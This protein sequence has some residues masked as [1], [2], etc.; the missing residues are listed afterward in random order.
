M[1][2]SPA[3]PRHHLDA[4]DKTDEYI[5]CQQVTGLMGE[6]ERS[7]GAWLGKVGGASVM[8]GRAGPTL[9]EWLWE[10]ARE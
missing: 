8:Y 4:E 2:R 3:C 9:D 1:P 7:E 10:E 5:I 6:Q